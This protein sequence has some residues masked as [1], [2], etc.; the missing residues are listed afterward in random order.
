MS[1]T[2]DR[3]IEAATTARVLLDRDNLAGGPSSIIGRTVASTVTR[4]RFIHRSEAPP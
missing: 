2:A 4:G 1:E 3:R